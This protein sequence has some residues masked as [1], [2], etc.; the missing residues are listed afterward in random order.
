MVLAIQS[1]G[2]PF[3]NAVIGYSPNNNRRGSSTPCFTRTR[4][5]TASLPSTMR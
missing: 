3:S 5:D 2:G 4:N 1:G